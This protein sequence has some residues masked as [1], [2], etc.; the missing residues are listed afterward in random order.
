[1]YAGS[2]PLIGGIAGGTLATTGAD[3]T[4]PIVIAAVALV[5]GG[6]LMI[7]DRHLHRQLAK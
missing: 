3:S 6:L 7:R 1:M 4:W 2:P 5:I